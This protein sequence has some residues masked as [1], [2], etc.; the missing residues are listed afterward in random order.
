MLRRGHFTPHPPAPSPSQGGEGEKNRLSV[1]FGRGTRPKD[2]DQLEP[3]F[4]LYT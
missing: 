1:S 2:T 3:T 4:Q